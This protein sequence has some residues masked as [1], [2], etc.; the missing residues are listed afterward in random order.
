MNDQDT[1]MSNEEWYDADVAPVLRDLADACK[2]R[3]MSMLAVVEWAP[4]D[5]G[6]TWATGGQAGIGIRMLETMARTG[7]NLDLFLMALYRGGLDL[8]ACLCVADALRR[9]P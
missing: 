5:G 1:V 4:G 2:A 6:R 9:K 3:G 7:D 8:S